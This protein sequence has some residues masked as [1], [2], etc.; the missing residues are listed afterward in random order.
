MPGGL[1]PLIRLTSVRRPVVA[2]CAATSILLGLLLIAAI[3]VWF[4]ERRANPGQ[5][6]ARPLAGIIDGLWWS[7]VTL[8]TVGYGDKAPKTRV[9]RVVAAI[10][11]FSAVVLIALF[12]AQVTTSLTVTSLN[13]RV[14]GPAD[15]PYVRVGALEASQSQVE[16]RAALGVYAAGYASFK[17]G[18]QA[19]DYGEIDAFVGAGP[20][21][22]YEI[23]NNF[24]GRLAFVG[25]PF[26]RVDYVFAFPLGSAIRKR[27]NE[28]LLLYIDTDEWRRLAHQY[29]GN[30]G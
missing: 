2:L 21:L 5:F 19:L 17:E 18:L 14:R 7:V 25:T 6:N 30:D 3:L 16:L 1:F 10:W 9:G 4:L 29:L 12:T 26:L 24:S 13:A 27:V 28:S 22:R 15:L 23:A 11:M 8:T 20:I